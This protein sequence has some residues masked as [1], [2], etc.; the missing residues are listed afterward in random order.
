[1]RHEDLVGL[2]DDLE[3]LRDALFD[4]AEGDA[5]PADTATRGTVA[6]DLLINSLKELAD[7]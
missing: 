4:V 3:E 6:L 2:S 7:D 5:M 1:M